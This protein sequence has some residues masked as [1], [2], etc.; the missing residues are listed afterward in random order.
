MLVSEGDLRHVVA[1]QAVAVD[2]YAYPK[3]TYGGLWA[4][5]TRVE[6]NPLSVHGGTFFRVVCRINFE[7][8]ALAGCG[9]TRGML[10][11]G[12]NGMGRIVSE[13]ERV[14]F[15]LFGGLATIARAR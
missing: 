5:V 13:K 6:L 7:K 8:S 11:P 12:L 1:G 15:R 3:E 14:I 4:D 2:L 9:I 10:R